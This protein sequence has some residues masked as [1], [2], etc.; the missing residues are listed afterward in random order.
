M[1]QDHRL[2]L[3]DRRPGTPVSERLLL[4]WAAANMAVCPDGSSTALWWDDPLSDHHTVVC[5]PPPPANQ[6]CPK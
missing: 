4:D 5:R 3:C 1:A 2:G 6:A